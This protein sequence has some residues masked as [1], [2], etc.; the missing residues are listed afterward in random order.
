MWMFLQIPVAKADTH[1]D[2]IKEIS[3]RYNL[4]GT[5]HV[6]GYHTYK[7]RNFVPEEF[8][9]TISTVTENKKCDDKGCHADIKA[10]ITIGLENGFVSG[11]YLQVDDDKLRM[12]IRVNNPTAIY[13]SD[14]LYEDCESEIISSTG[15]TCTEKCDTC[16]QGLTTSGVEI[17]LP[18]TSGWGCNHWSCWSV[19]EGATCGKCHHKKKGDCYKVMKL[20]KQYV[21]AEVCLEIENIGQC[22]LTTDKDA[23]TSEILNLIML[24]SEPLMHD[25]IVAENLNMF[26]KGSI[27]DLGEYDNKFGALQFQT[28]AITNCYKEPKYNHKCIFGQ[29]RWLDI[30][31]CCKDTHW[32][33]KNLLAAEDLK[34]VPGEEKMQTRKTIYQ[35]VKKYGTARMVLKLDRFPITEINNELEVISLKLH[36]FAGCPLCREGATVQ[37]LINTNMPGKLRVDSTDATLTTNYWILNGKNS[38]VNFGFKSWHSHGNLTL[39]LNHKTFVFG[40]QLEDLRKELNEETHSPH[41]TNKEGGKDCSTI[42]C[43]LG[44]YYR[45]TIKRIQNWIGGSIWRLLSVIL[46]SVLLVASYIIILFVII[47]KIVFTLSIPHKEKDD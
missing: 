46:I 30:T 3:R 11:F 44:D 24:S 38:T 21:T 15:D 32:M 18:D 34:I 1:D 14:Y 4:S 6:D 29:H 47:R 13:L 7:V 37:A 23:A 35:N 10:D 8:M 36:K 45:H 31:G 41:H 40:Y 43:G 17:C 33:K 9:T 42:E 22:I 25:Q 27:N 2:I 12:A 19:G 28:P 16:L 20:K 26:Y 5:H 39:I